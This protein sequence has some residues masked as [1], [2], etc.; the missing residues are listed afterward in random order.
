MSS[1]QLVLVTPLPLPCCPVAVAVAVALACLININIINYRPNFGRPFQKKLPSQ[2][3]RGS[4][5]ERAGQPK[6]SKS[7]MAKNKGSNT[8]I[9]LVPITTLSQQT[10]HSICLGVR[11]YEDRGLIWI[12]LFVFIHTFLH[13][14]VWSERSLVKEIQYLIIIFVF[15]HRSAKYMCCLCIYFRIYLSILCI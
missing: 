4:H 3:K 9:Q 7:T 11:F 10:D 1:N 6:N 2:K 15:P 8:A 13:F 14:L 5:R 12:A